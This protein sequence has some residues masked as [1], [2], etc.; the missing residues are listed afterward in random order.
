MTADR[1]KARAVIALMKSV[2]VGRSKFFFAMVIGVKNEYWNYQPFT[3]A[4]INPQTPFD[5]NVSATN[6]F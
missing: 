5:G 3:G 4:D 2:I 6:N 1:A